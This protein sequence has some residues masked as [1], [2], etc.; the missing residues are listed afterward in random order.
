MFRERGRLARFSGKRGEGASWRRAR[1]TS[2]QEILEADIKCRV[3]VRGE[4]GSLLAGHVLWLSV[5]VSYCVPDLSTAPTAGTRQSNSATFTFA[6][7][8]RQLTSGAQGTTHMH[9]HAH[10]IA[11]APTDNRRHHHQRVLGHKVPYASLLLAVV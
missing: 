3:G 5:L 4:D 9:V 6:S 11:L 1:R 10:A 2:S 8:K 7:G